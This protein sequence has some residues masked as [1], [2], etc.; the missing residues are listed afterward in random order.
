[1]SEQGFKAEEVRIGRE[2]RI[3]RGV[4][5]E[6]FKG[7][8]M[9]TLIIGDCTHF[10]EGTRVLTS[11][12][13]IGDYCKIH[14]H[15][16]IIGEGSCTIG[17]NCWIG[18]R[19]V[20]NTNG[21]LTIGNN[22]ALGMGSVIWTHARAGELLEGTL[23]CY[24]RPVI[25]E[26]DVWLVGGNIIISPGVTLAKGTVVLPGAVITKDTKEKRCYAGVPA[27]DI[28]DKVK[29]W[30]QV[31]LQ[32]KVSMMRGFVREFIDHIGG[33]RE[34]VGGYKCNLGEIIFVEDTSRK[35]PIGKV[36][37]IVIT[38]GDI[39]DIVSTTCSYFSLST[40]TYTKNFTPL[41]IDFIRFM[42]S[43]RARFLPVEVR[44]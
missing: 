41:E 40:K 20:L 1:M 16:L 28:T 22:V 12:L 3:D 25:I 19:T 29:V 34:I 27:K 2:V 37:R 17:H 35:I 44:T 30:R 6:G 9:K 5:F 26:D 4:V 10:A 13:S 8:S 15:S 43:Y 36:D 7:E 11:S 24:E 38:M 14:N 18:E 39:P 33:G 31:T 21:N 42:V 23:L 32:E